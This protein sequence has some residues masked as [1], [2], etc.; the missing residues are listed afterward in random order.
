[1]DRE[2]PSI[3][4]SE[5]IGKKLK[6]IQDDLQL[7]IRGLFFIFYFDE[8]I[9]VNSYGVPCVRISYPDDYKDEEMDDIE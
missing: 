8:R 1:M 3:E 6:E 2:P 4:E 7:P 5:E 9:I